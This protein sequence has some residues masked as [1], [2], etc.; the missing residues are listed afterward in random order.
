MRLTGPVTMADDEFGTLQDG[1][2]VNA[3]GT[4][5]IVLIILWLALRSGQGSSSPSSS[6]CSSALP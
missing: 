6:I 4:I 1:A 3:I 5:V 2:L